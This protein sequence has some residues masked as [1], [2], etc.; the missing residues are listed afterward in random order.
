MSNKQNDKIL[1]EQFELL[2][3]IRKQL[4]PKST[5][6]LDTL[7]SAEEMEQE[8]RHLME[9]DEPTV[10]VGGKLMDTV[11]YERFNDQ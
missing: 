6:I 8:C 4:V 11:D 3:H 10:N 5:A 7:P 9:I 1:E 2:S